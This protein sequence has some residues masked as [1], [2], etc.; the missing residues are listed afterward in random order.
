M[1]VDFTVRNF[2]SF[3]EEATLSLHA[4]KSIKDHENSSDS[5]NMI[6]L[7]GS[8][9]RLLKV[10]A[11][12]GANASGKSNFIAAISFFRRM[13]LKSFSDD[14]ILENF[15]QRKFQLNTLA[16]DS[17]SFFEM[18]FIIDECRY[19]YGFEIEGET[20]S[21]EWLFM[22]D[23]QAP[24]ESYC[25]K[26]EK[27]KIQINPKTYKGAAGLDVKTRDNSLFLSTCAQ[28]NIDVAILIKKWFITDL[29]IILDNSLPP[30]LTIDILRTNPEKQKIIM[31]FIKLIDLSINKITIEEHEAR[32]LPKPLEK[33]L[34]D[35]AKNSEAL[36][37]EL[38]DARKLEVF[39]EHDR[40]TGQEF[41]DS[42]RFPF[43]WES[44]GTKKIFSLVGPWFDTIL[45]GGILVIDEF[46]SSLHTSISLE[47]LKIFQS[48]LN[49]KAQLIIATHD[50]NLLAK[51]IL[52]RDQIWFV[53]K[54]KYGATDLYSLV[55]YKL[56]KASGGNNES[57]TKD[58]YLMGKYGAIPYFGDLSK[59]L[60]E[61]SGD[62]K[63]D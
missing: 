15:A 58:H 57:F 23:L 56:D 14:T 34:S 18:V 61:F 53:E 38:K 8:N 12:Y 26:R 5:S 43:S 44:L 52:R 25:F 1:L 37:F 28:F 40:Y 33:L 3:K 7:N 45:R 55:E 29:N 6:V 4:E 50:T 27:Q 11:I 49:K 20:I 42:V 30:T 13:I 9:E 22:K 2:R 35:I 47:M 41:K 63:E 19:R 62:D 46:G 48:H 54:D 21:L 10:A 31:D 16:K 39:S 51:D 59:F 17:P 24:R 32:E 36:K 60:K